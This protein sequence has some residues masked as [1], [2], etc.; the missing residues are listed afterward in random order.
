MNESPIPQ[1]KYIPASRHNDLV[2]TSGMTPR[3]NGVLQFSGPVKASEPI[4]TYREAVRLAAGNALTA[5]RAAVGTQEYISRVV[6][7][8][9]FIATAEG[10][11]AHARV[12]DFAS[13]YF[14]EELGD[15]GVGS[16][17]AIGVA[18]LPGNAPVEIQLVAA[19]SKRSA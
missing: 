16:R 5:A 15:D 8:S 14:H 3:I 7:L 11:T 6:T 18:S 2:Y 1:G 9:V 13:E 4:E 12:A 17:A 19:V 10:F